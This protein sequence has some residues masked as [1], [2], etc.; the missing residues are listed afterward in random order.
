MIE[1]KYSKIAFTD[2]G[3]CVFFHDGSCC[4]AIPHDIPHYHVIAH[5]LG[6]GDDRMRYCREHEFAHLFVEERLHDRPSR[7]LWAI[8]HDQMLTG[9]EAAY[10]ESFAQVFQRWL[11]AHERPI[12]SGVDWDGLKRDALALLP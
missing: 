8:A 10:E 12:L 6:Y 2:R 11:R 3:C 5:R 7:V 1:L 4:N 9:P